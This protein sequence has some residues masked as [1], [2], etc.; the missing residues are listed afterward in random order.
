MIILITYKV[1]KL[2][3]MGEVK[4]VFKK[5]NLVLKVA[6]L[7]IAY[8]VLI[9][10]NGSFVMVGEPKLPKRMKKEDNML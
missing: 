7:L 10:M 6:T 3:D 1:L 4:R 5:R 9:P 8:A 2:T